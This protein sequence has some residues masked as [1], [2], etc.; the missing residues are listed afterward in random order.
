M[1][2]EIVVPPIHHLPAILKVF[3]RVVGSSHIVSLGMGKLPFDPVAIEPSF[4]KDRRSRSPKAVNS[5]PSVV[6]Q[7]IN[8]IEPRVF[9]NDTG[10][11]W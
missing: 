4:V 9:R 7:A 6:A 2:I 8:G 1:P 11:G 10:F 5:Q 3:S